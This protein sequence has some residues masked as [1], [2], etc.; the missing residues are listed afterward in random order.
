M[1]KLLSAIFILAVSLWAT[2]HESYCN[3]PS[4]PNSNPEGSCVQN[5]YVCNLGF[6]IVGE[7]NIMHFNLGADSTCTDLLTSSL[8]PKDST[9]DST[10]WIFLWENREN[11]GPLS[12]TLAGSLAMHA[13][14]NNQQVSI[15][16][17]KVGNVPFGGIKLLSIQ[18]INTPATTTP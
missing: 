15:I 7:D 11:M 4:T 3:T 5:G 18:L 1:K 10:A 8:A 13:F 2:T 16:Y 14:N 17:K 9:Q 6:N 12:L